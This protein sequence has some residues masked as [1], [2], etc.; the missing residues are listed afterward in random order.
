MKIKVLF[1]ET[2][3]LGLDVGNLVG[4]KFVFV[5][6]HSCGLEILE[7]AEFR[8]E[9]EEKGTTTSSCTCSS[10]NTMDVFAWIIGWIVLNDPIDGRD[11]ETT[12]SNIGAK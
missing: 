12:S 9:K 5:E 3:E 7:E 1:K 2:L 8:G 10:T 11:I 6:G 4:W